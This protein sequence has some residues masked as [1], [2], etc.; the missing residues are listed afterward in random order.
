MNLR[1]KRRITLGTACIFFV[2]TGI[3]HAVILPSLW[4]YLKG[5]FQS[6]DYAIAVV[7]SACCVTAL[8]VSPFVG[9]WADGTRNVRSVLLVVNLGQFVGS[10]LYFA[11]ISHWLLLVARLLSG[12]GT[13]TAAVILADAARSTA[14]KDRT[15][16]FA[17]LAGF[18]E[19]GI[20][21]GSSLHVFF[22]N[23]NLSIGV[24]PLDR[25]S[26][27]ALM[28]AFLWL[29]VEAIFYLAY[30]NMAQLSHQQ[31][32]E[33]T[34]QCSY[35]EASM[36]NVSECLPPPSPYPQHH[37]IQPD[38]DHTDSI[39]Y[40]AG[41]LS[42]RYPHPHRTM[43][44]CLLDLFR[45]APKLKFDILHPLVCTLSFCSE[46][47]TCN[48]SLAPLMCS[49][50]NDLAKMHRSPLNLSLDEGD[51]FSDAMIETAERFILSSESANPGA[52]FR[53]VLR[54]PSSAALYP[55][56]NENYRYGE[57]KSIAIYLVCG[58]E[59]LLVFA[60]IRILSRQLSDRLLLLVGLVFTCVGTF[61]W[62]GFGF[63]AS[64][65]KFNSLPLFVLGTAVDLFGMPMLTVCTSSLIS[66][67][68]SSKRQ[69]TCSSLRF[70]NL[71]RSRRTR[72]ER[73]Q[74]R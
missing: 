59:V 55:L 36:G 23:E 24:L 29:L 10:L 35:L 15:A 32:L 39:G 56:A 27:P 6:P 21:V 62:L 18:R 63:V 43:Q 16:T 64:P 57:M 51:L 26:I 31:K 53:S 9:V 5:R 48:L 50:N 54:A 3:E 47:E 38:L 22:Q 34:L 13:G 71:V 61:L 49:L 68:T 12:L 69:G 60:G 25:Y 17:L 67:V 42:S 1:T 11:G 30:F 8:F 33:D 14:E 20:V 40:S 65:G 37:D 45:T 2:I 41:A 70:H 28:M 73:T 66:K 4:M 72:M 7:I 52:G 44:A 46:Y 19:L 58:V 74:K